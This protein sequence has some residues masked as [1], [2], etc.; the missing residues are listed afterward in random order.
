MHQCKQFIFSQPLLLGENVIR[1]LSYVDVNSFM[2]L[3]LFAYLMVRT[4]GLPDFPGAGFKLKSSA[5][6]GPPGL[7]KIL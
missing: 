5:K 6:L 3:L 7:T 1:I 4:H 2:N